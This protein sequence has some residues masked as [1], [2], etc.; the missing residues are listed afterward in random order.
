MES[1]RAATDTDIFPDTDIDKCDT[2]I[3]QPL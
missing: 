3:Q 1:E 2:I